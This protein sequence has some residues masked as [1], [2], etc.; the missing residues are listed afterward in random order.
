MEKAW[1]SRG[2]AVEKQWPGGIREAVER[3]GGKGVWKSSGKSS[4]EAV[5]QQ[6]PGGIREA[7]ERQGGKAVWD[8]SGNGVGKRVGIGGAAVIGETTEST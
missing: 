5:E 8:R 7:V 1:K 6:W 2:E 3:Q 4:G